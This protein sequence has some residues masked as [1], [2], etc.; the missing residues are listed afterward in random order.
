MA[1]LTRWRDDARHMR[2]KS[3]RT[4]RR[5]PKLLRRKAEIKTR[6]AK[7]RLLVELELHQTRAQ[8]EL[9]RLKRLERGI[10]LS[11]DRLEAVHQSFPIAYVSLD[12]K[13]TITDWNPVALRLLAEGKRTLAGV[14]FTLFLVRQDVEIGLDHLRRCR[15]TRSGEIVSE[16]RLKQGKRPPI[17]VQMVSV[18]FVPGPKVIYL[19]ALVDLTEREKGERATAEAKQFSEAIIDTIHE[20]LLV[21]DEG[22]KILHLNKACAKMFQIDLPLVRGLSFESLLNLWWTGNALRQQ[23]ERTL[24]DDVP[25]SNVE[26]EVHP[27]GLGRR[28]LLCN[29]RRVHARDGSP[30]VLLVALEDITARKKAEEDLAQTNRQLQDL[31]V[32]LEKH[33]ET[34]TRELLQSNQQLES[35]CYSIAHDLRCPLRAMTGFSSALEDDF[36][37]QLGPRGKDYIERIVSAGQQMNML[38]NDLLDYG[39]VSTIELIKSPIATDDVLSR[40]L[41]DLQPVI[42]E[43]RA[44]I[45]RRGPLPHVLGHRAV[46]ETCFSNL[47][48]NALKF[49]APDVPPEVAIYSEQI[50]NDVRIWIAD[51]GIGIEPQYQGKIFKVFQRLH[52]QDQYPGTGIGLAI[53]SRA[54]QRING[55]IGVESEPGKGSRFWINLPKPESAEA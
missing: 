41:Q 12:P 45:E 8:I 37:T 4:V 5:R 6:E 17:P 1:T 43:K 3:T 21:L 30:P 2:E 34:R 36:S 13:G 24:R 26:F 7:D 18:P 42:E 40:V 28:I 9:E 39:R 33:V 52:A 29:A 44:H 23:L 53:V 55:S 54:L 15:H 27:R 20:S 16:V 35:F 49:V 46:L 11:R 14:P 25:L 10:Q 19:T 47:L 38:I 31:N 22:L 51:N 48:N 32:H 50:Q